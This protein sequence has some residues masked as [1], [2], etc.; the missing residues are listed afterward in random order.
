MYKT[1]KT[2]LSENSTVSDHSPLAWTSLRSANAFHLPN[3]IKAFDE[4]EKQAIGPDDLATRIYGFTSTDQVAVLL[5]VFTGV[6]LLLILAILIHHT[7]REGSVHQILIE[8]TKKPPELTLREG[9]HYHL[10]NS[11]IWSTGQDAV[12]TIKRQLQRLV[13]G[14]RVFL[15]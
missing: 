8:A 3:Y 5:L 6:M 12:A 2:A 4:T 14:V 15:E 7:A 13:L 1:R 9:Q 10:F 11:H